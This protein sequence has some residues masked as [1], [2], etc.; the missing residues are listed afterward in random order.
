MKLLYLSN[1]RLPTEKAYGIQITKM[2]EAFSEKVIVELVIPTR[3][4]SIDKT[5]F[6]YYGVKNSF[7]VKILSSPDFYFPGKL[8]KVAFLIKNFL[9]ALVLFRYVLLKK[10]DIVFSRDELP[11]YFLSFF[12]KNLI[13]EAHKFSSRRFRYY[14]RFKRAGIRI[15]VISAG[16]RDEFVKFGFKP[17][18][19]L[20]AHDGVDIEQFNILESQEECRRKLGLPL[21]KKLIGYVGQLKTMGME[22]GIGVLL[23]AFAILKKDFDNLS[24]VIVGGDKED[25]ASYKEISQKRGLTEN[26]VLFVGRKEYKEIPYYLRSFSVLV[27]PFPNKPHYALYMS[28]LKLFEYMASGRPIV[29]SDLPTVREVL[30]SNNSVLVEPDNA[31]SLSIGIK[32]IVNDENLTKIISEKASEK[33]KNL[34]WVKRAIKIL[35]FIK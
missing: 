2:C 20:V 27:M 16:L 29:T 12:K 25:V 34:T 10:T 5:V 35:E 4:N 30:D 17:G 14:S 22:K 8:D 11:L 15:I 23:E 31:K 28:P 9:S 26:D 3:N 21:D 18:K 33:I 1:L 6:E 19:I 7:K 13:F 32:K 24:L